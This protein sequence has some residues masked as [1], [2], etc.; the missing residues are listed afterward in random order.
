MKQYYKSIKEELDYEA[1]LYAEKLLKK[2]WRYMKEEAELFLIHAFSHLFEISAK[3]YDLLGSDEHKTKYSQFYLNLAVGLELL[4][5][6][7]LLKK[8]IGVNING[9][10][11][12]QFSY[13][14][15]HHLNGILSGLSAN[16]LSEVK[17]T[18][19]LINAK[20]NNI[21][22]R[23]K[24]IYE[25]YAYEH[26]FSYVTLYIY[27]RFFYGQNESLVRLLLKSIE[28]SRITSGMDF[29][30]M[31]ITPKSLRSTPDSE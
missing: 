25:H 14:I 3:G 12:R 6:S 29:K 5:K 21:A 1:E 19:M 2:D 30:S 4:L 17:A 23:S 8:R 18:L 16:T 20:R 24:R 28:R 7:I 22:H 11:T 15:E 13:I 31:R 9:K 26:R 10:R 27:E